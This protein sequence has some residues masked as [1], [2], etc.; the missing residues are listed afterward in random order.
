MRRRQRILITIS[1][2]IL[3]LFHTTLFTFYKQ[4]GSRPS[5]QSCLYFHDFQSAM[6]FKY[7]LVLW[8]NKEIE[9]YSSDFSASFIDIPLVIDIPY[10]SQ[11]LKQF[12]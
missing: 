11:R 12:L 6:M 7:C 1:R 4:L 2:V 9:V 5:P 3:F 10:I 8:P